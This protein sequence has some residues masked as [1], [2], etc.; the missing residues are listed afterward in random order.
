MLLALALLAATVLAADL[1]AGFDPA[2]WP[3]RKEPSAEYKALV[4]QLRE[5]QK[6][7]DAAKVKQIVAEIRKDLGSYAGVPEV[8]PE[9]GTPIERTE[10]NLNAV[11]AICWRSFESLK[12]SNGWELAAR[13]KPNQQP[14]L[15]VTFRTTMSNLRAFEAGVP[16]AEE[17]RAAGIQGLDYL[18]TQQAS[19]GVFG[20]PYDPNATSGLKVQAAAIARRGAGSGLKMTEGAWLIEDLDDGGLQFDNGVAG[21]GLL[22]GYALTGNRKYLDSA[23]RA[24]DWAVGRPIVP[25]WNYNS[26]SGYLLARMYRVTG[27]RKYLEAAI[28]K[29]EVGVL[30]GQMDNG[31]WVDQHN[32]RPNYHSLMI[33]NLVEY[34]LALEQAK[35]SRAA[36]V[37]RRTKLA[38]DSL[39]EETDRYGAPNTDEGLPLEALSISL[40]AFGPSPAW[41]EAA[42]IQVNYAVNHLLPGLIEARR[43]RPET[44]T[45]YVLWRRVQERRARSCEVSITECLRDRK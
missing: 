17:Y 43:G 32:A 7:H 30:P 8:K 18:V 28:D 3:G 38:L 10:P 26:Y 4:N 41:E 2:H 27:E 25:N 35:D 16:H 19:T 15:R 13:A 31:R 24:A 39:A 42:N 22:Y 45:A 40:I 11:E 36:E 21:A 12:G 29:F 37:R 20:Y 33:R 5:A 23:R 6:Q 34:T 14:R 9:Y 44:L 1:P